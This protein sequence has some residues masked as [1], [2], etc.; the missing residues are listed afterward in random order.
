[1]GPCQARKTPQGRQAVEPRCS[2]YSTW[3]FPE[4]V[5]HRMFMCI[6]VLGSWVDWLKLNFGVGVLAATCYDSS[7]RRVGFP[8]LLYS[9]AGLEHHVL[10]RTSYTRPAICRLNGRG[11]MGLLLWGGAGDDPSEKVACKQG[12]VSKGCC[13]DFKKQGETTNLCFYFPVL[14]KTLFALTGLVVAPSRPFS[15]TY[16]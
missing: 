15:K 2:N 11:H 7:S 16:F 1:M 4:Y 9:P 3:C 8:E 6:T 14:F 13:R 10:T 12:W 5:F